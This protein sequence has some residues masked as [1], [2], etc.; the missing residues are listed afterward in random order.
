VF[1]C[2]R[3][4]IPNEDQGTIY[5]NVTTPPGSTL[6]RT[7]YIMDE[8]T[9]IARDFESVESVSTLSGYSLM[10]EGSGSSYGMA[11]INFKPWEEREQSVNEVAT[12]LTQATRH[13]KDA[14]IQFFPPPAVPGYGNASGF[15][16]RLQDRTNARDLQKLQAIADDFVQKLNERPEIINAFTSYDAS[17]PQ[18]LISIDKDKAAQKGVTAENALSN[19]QAVIGS[20][21]ATNFIR[22]GQLYKVMVQALPEYRA[23]PQDIEKLYVKK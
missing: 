20:F 19:L 6:E 1:L 11:M 3:G 2:Q 23:Q 14:S 5:A 21:Y 7:D 9:K 22:F 15:E 12:E 16:L 13:L 8:I 10:T 18:Y 17:F 4:F